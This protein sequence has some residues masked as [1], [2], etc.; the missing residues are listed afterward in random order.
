GE[1]QITDAMA[2]LLEREKMLGFTF[3]EGRYDTG[4]KSDYLRAVVEM[5]LARP[6]LGPEFRTLLGEI[7]AR[8]GLTGTS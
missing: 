1:I 4:K 7:A 6:D 5:A 2:T 8:E 3:T